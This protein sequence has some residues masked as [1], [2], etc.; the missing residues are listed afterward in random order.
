[1]LAGGISFYVHISLFRGKIKK[2]FTAIEPK[3]LFLFIVIGVVLSM[4]FFTDL[5]IVIFQIVSAFTGT[6]FSIA[7]NRLFRI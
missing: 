3:M 2:F 5:K 7:D 4:L 1:M 6:G